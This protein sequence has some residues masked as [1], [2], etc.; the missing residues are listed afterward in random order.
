MLPFF[1]N[2]Q[3]NITNQFLNFKFTNNKENLVLI[4]K[5]Q[6]KIENYKSKQKRKAAKSKAKCQIKKQFYIW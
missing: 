4:Y 5:M 3:K 1:F 6:G 2:I